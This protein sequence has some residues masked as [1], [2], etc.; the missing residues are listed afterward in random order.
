MG[1]TESTR[2]RVFAYFF[3]FLLGIL[4]AAALPLGVTFF[5]GLIYCFDSTAI[6]CTFVFVLMFAYL[7]CLLL[8]AL[9]AASMWSKAGRLRMRS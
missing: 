7:G 3:L 4:L 1:I 5:M 2:F 6:N 8:S 9:G